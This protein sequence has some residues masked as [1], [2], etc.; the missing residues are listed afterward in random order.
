MKRLTRSVS[1][2]SA[3]SNAIKV[4][5]FALSKN[6]KVILRL[7]QIHSKRHKKIY[8]VIM[9]YFCYN[10]KRINCILYM[11]IQYGFLISNYVHFFGPLYDEYRKT[12]SL[13][14]CPVL[15]EYI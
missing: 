4:I 3:T 11:K 8:Q 2:S 1:Y 13:I 6:K 15:H 5:D 14:N 9:A 12:A 7:Q 10:V